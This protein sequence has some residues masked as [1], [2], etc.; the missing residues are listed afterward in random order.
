MANMMFICTKKEGKKGKYGIGSKVQLNPNVL[1][2]NGL[3]C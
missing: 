1:S 3:S 2:I